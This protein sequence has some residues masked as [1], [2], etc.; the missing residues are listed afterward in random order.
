MILKVYDFISASGKKEYHLYQDDSEFPVLI[1]ENGDEID[2]KILELGQEYVDK[3]TDIVVED[4]MYMNRPTRL[5]KF[6]INVNKPKK[7]NI[8]SLK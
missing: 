8:I 2:A 1:T 4:V 5:Y 3:P 7:E 6:I